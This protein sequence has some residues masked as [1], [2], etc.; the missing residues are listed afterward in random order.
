MTSS[1]AGELETLRAE[2]AALRQRLSTATVREAFRL[3]PHESRVLMAL[4]GAY[5]KVLSAETIASVIPPRDHAK[6]RP[7][8][9]GRVRVFGLKRKLGEECIVNIRGEGYALTPAG[10]E[11]VRD[12]LEAAA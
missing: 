11:E 1:A 7:S 3:D 8:N 9:V 2:N 12:A 10:M 6:L 4:F 5:P